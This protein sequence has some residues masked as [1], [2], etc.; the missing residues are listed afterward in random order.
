MSTLVTIPYA[1]RQFQREI[2]ALLDDKRFVVA[3]CHRRFGK[4]VC[5]VN[6]LLKSA[7][8]CQKPR[9][10]FAYIAPTFRQGK[11]VAWDYLKHFAS[12]V[13][14]VTVN[15]SELRIK[16]PNEAEIRIFGSDNPD[17]LRGLYIDGAVLDEYGMQAATVFSEVLRPA[18][19]DRQ[20]WALFLGTPN[21]KNQFFDLAQYARTSGDALWGF[22]EYKASQTGYVLQSELEAAEA[23]MTPDEYRQEWECSFEAS[24][25]GAI[26]AAQ[27]QQ[28]R[29]DGRITRVPYDP[30][31]PVDTDWDLG[32]GDAMAIWFSQSTRGGEVR[33]IEYLEGSGEGFP[34][35]AALLSSRGYVYG[36]HWAPHDI[37]V[38]E[39]GTGKSRLQTAAEFGI[40]FEVTPRLQRSSA[41]QE[42]EEG[43]HA[44]R[45]L[46]PRCWFDEQKC[47]RG[48]EALQHYRRDYNSRLNEFKAT[49][50]HDFASH[51]ADAFRGLAVRHQPPK[52]KKRQEEFPG[53]PSQGG[54]S[55]AS[56]LGG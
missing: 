28:A 56:W 24:V 23:V 44:V 10:R 51:G 48:I 3:V 11:A 16:L 45:M 8:I 18:L 47:L 31:L 37:A 9:G 22:V 17:S 53:L 55:G 25:K 43:I 14:G 7:L 26:Y 27:L 4:T 40:R 41:G 6:H 46:F 42:V 49:P 30:G 33:L 21:G 5:A 13:P 39:L 2:H 29:E 36:Q 32:I 19:A 34:H 52:A 50:V 20:G 12:A 54:R 35:Y 15:E 38:R 1:P